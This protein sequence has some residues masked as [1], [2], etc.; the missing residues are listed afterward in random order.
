M[1]IRRWNKIGLVALSP[2]RFVGWYFGLWKREDT[3]TAW[4]ITIVS[5][6][7][8]G[9]CGS[10]F[11]HSQYLDRINSI[12]DPAVLKA[13]SEADTCFRGTMSRRIADWNR[14]AT[15]KDVDQLKS[16]CVQYWIDQRAMTVQKAAIQ[17]Q[18]KA[19]K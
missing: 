17:E 12:A 15:V 18:L 10:V 13:E 19:S 4:W 7:A 2:F 3:E 5:I 14:P 8:S 16:E 11:W 9:I 6:A 1:W